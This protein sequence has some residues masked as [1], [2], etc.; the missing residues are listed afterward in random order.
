M[1]IQELLALLGNSSNSNPIEQ[2]SQ[3]RQLIDP[4]ELD[5][6]IVRTG[7][8]G[9][10]RPL[11]SKLQY[12]PDQIN[13]MNAYTDYQ[14]R[15]TETPVRSHTYM[16]NRIQATG[17]LEE[18]MGKGSSSNG[19]SGSFLSGLGGQELANLSQS[20]SG[21]ANP[22]QDIVRKLL[23]SLI[24]QPDIPRV[25]N[26]GRMTMSQLSALTGGQSSTL[27][28]GTGTSQDETARL[29]A[30]YTKGAATTDSDL[31]MAKQRREALAK[32]MPG[33]TSAMEG[34]GTQWSSMN[35]IL[36][37]Q[38]AERAAE[39]AAAL[40][41]KQAVQY[42]DIS[43]RLLAAKGSYD[44]QMSNQRSADIARLLDSLK[45]SNSFSLGLHQ[46]RPP[47]AGGSSGGG[48]SARP[49]AKSSSVA[50]RGIYDSEPKSK[51]ELAK[52]QYDLDHFYDWMKRP[53]EPQ[54][55]TSSMIREFADSYIPSPGSGSGSFTNNLTGDTTL[56]GR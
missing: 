31:L 23:L 15:F 26:D 32:V 46:S 27:P 44:A 20:S 14:E 8:D 36:Q 2:A 12:S 9:S 41:A 17:T 47:Q 35:A 16:Q 25:T 10:G 22:D 37:Q 13:Q 30:D 21:L 28:P 55:D 54:Q 39:D 19:G 6:T 34:S 53:D 11:Y 18:L 49:A 3:A 1:D 45:S 52:N 50:T 43:Q 48:G 40:G 24:A 51:E 29:L 5:P 56:V 42:G 4:S 33:I 7:T 38:A